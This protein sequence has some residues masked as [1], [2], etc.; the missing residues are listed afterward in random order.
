MKYIDEEFKSINTENYNIKPNNSL[1]APNIYPPY[2]GKSDG[3]YPVFVKIPLYPHVA[4]GDSITVNI[5]GVS[6]P[7]YEILSDDI[8]NEIIIY[9]DRKN[10]PA[11]KIL[12]GNDI[13]ISYTVDNNDNYEEDNLSLPQYLKIIDSADKK[14]SSLK[15]YNDLVFTDDEKLNLNRYNS[16]IGIKKESIKDIKIKKS[17][18]L[19]SSSDKEFTYFDYYEYEQL[20]INLIFLINTLKLYNTEEKQFNAWVV[21]ISD[22]NGVDTIYSTDM[23]NIKIPNTI[24]IG[25]NAIADSYYSQSYKQYKS[26]INRN[27]VEF[28]LINDDNMIKEGDILEININYSY[29]EYDFKIPFTNKNLLNNLVIP[30]ININDDSYFPQR[31]IDIKY[32]I[33]KEKY[34][35]IG[36]DITYS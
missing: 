34:T 21:V 33:L 1:K 36:N 9:I 4:V 23:T 10:I 29:D 5:G 24:D 31:N 11:D 8:N 27:Y 13:Q 16:V 19:L 22:K 12:S 26:T 18:L 6:S 28:S 30:I 2:I 20:N 32:K 14:L 7:S 3:D 17:Y 15:L 25:C 35:I